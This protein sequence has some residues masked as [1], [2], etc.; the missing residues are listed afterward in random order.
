MLTKRLPL[1]ISLGLTGSA[2][3]SV[4]LLC[5]LLGHNDC[6]FVLFCLT[7]LS[8]I[9]TADAL[10]GDRISR[11]LGRKPPNDYFLKDHGEEARAFVGRIQR[12]EATI[13]ITAIV[14]AVLLTVSAAI[15]RLLARAT[16]SV[17]FILLH[18][19]IRA[20]LLVGVAVAG[21]MRVGAAVARKMAGERDP[22]W[23][24]YKSRL[25]SRGGYR[26][27]TTRN[28]LWLI[29][30]A[31]A[32]FVCSFSYVRL[33]PDGMISRYCFGSDEELHKWS[34]V[35]RIEESHRLTIGPKGGGS[36]NVDYAIMFSDGF[37]WEDDMWYGGSRMR[38]PF[39]V[40]CSTAQNAVDYA[41]R[42]SGMA[43]TYWG[44]D[45]D[46]I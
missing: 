19:F 5:R 7:T 22:L 46:H 45:H 42:R 17:S 23:V 35:R 30:L 12:V 38:F 6:S 43:V 18:P 31:I 37:A 16:G 33:T 14:I 24:D 32:A 25:S 8:A 26:E 13:I 21:G 15:E 40:D 4:R 39:L 28:S 36:E 11:G 2:W 20:L 34:S 9:L 3:A 41:S 44:R 10:L 1:V 27:N 29:P